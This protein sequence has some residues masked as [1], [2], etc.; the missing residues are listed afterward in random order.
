[1]RALYH[2]YF[3]PGVCSL[4]RTV[5]E[6]VAIKEAAGSLD[7]VSDIASLCEIPILSGDDGL[8]LPMMAVGAAGVVSVV[9][10]F[11]PRMLLD[12]VKAA[13]AGDY[14]TARTL[15]Y[16]LLPI[17]KAMFMDV[18]PVPVKRALHLA[19]CISTPAVR[20][21]LVGLSTEVDEK[22]QAAL[23]TVLASA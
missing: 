16:T 3:L 10:N 18:N 22:L 20:L 9:S 6:V 1:M 23:K 19:G 14:V 4:W 11:Q 5:P 7:Q 8:T 12:L 21:P 2:P 15:H 13:A 17:I